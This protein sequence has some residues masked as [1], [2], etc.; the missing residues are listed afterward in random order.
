M[1]RI[2]ILQQWYALKNPAME[3]VLY[4]IPKLRLFAHLTTW[5]RFS[6]APTT[7]NFRRLLE[8]HGLATRILEAVTRI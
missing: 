5:T 8:P 1:F 2:H 6:D 4:Q 7:L 3:E